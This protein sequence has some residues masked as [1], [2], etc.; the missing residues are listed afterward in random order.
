M[1]GETFRS[2]LGFLRHNKWVV[3]G[4]LSPLL[5]FGALLLYGTIT[6]NESMLPAGPALVLGSVV[7]LALA[8]VHNPLPRSELE[9]VTASREGLVVGKRSYPRRAFRAGFYLHENGRSFVRLVRRV[10]GLPPLDLVV[11]DQAE[12]QALLRALGL[13]AQH[14]TTRFYGTSMVSNDP[15]KWTGITV[16]VVLAGFLLG[17]V[18][19]GMPFFLALLAAVA[20]Q[21]VPCVVDVGADGVHIRWLHT[22]RFIRASEIAGLYDYEVRFNKSY[23]MGVELRLRSGE[24]VR[25]PVGSPYW[26]RNGTAM[27]ISRIREVVHVAPRVHGADVAVLAR[28][29]EDARSWLQRLR[30]LGAG[31]NATLRTAPVQPEALWRVV[32]DVN[33]APRMRVAAAAALAK[34]VDPTE[35]ARIAL[36]AGATADP[37]LRVAFE[38]TASDDDA[39]VERALDELGDDARR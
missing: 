33:A 31:A 7:L 17:S 16:L 37:R 28:G 21:F 36:V 13:D 18:L 4:A 30:A 11:L 3:A 6:G 26:S 35:K 29:D 2:E 10:P 22:R 14:S 15:W 24:S 32:E 38:A 25:I 39:E 5:F 9:P 34:S 20:L 8:L 1:A 23:V 27:L 12:G 19:G